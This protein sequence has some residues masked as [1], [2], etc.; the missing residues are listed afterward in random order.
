MENII[1]SIKSRLRK[2]QKEYMITLNKAIDM[3]DAYG[4]EYNSQRMNA[5]NEFLVIIKEEQNSYSVLTHD[6]T[7]FSDN[8]PTFPKT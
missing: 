1:E 3:N 6:C 2:R 4:I 5:I 8:I 7:Y